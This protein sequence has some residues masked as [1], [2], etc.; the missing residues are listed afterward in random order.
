MTQLMFP[1][2]IAEHHAN[3]S[4]APSSAFGRE[5]LTMRYSIVR[6]SLRFFST[7]VAF[8][9]RELLVG[10]GS[11]LFAILSLWGAIVCGI[12][13][14]VFSL[15]ASG[16]NVALTRILAQ[17]AGFF[18]LF[19]ALGSFFAVRSWQKIQRV[20]TREKTAGVT[21]G[22]IEGKAAAMGE[23]LTGRSRE[24]AA[25]SGAISSDPLVGELHHRISSATESF[26]S[27]VQP[28]YDAWHKISEIRNNFRNEVKTNPLQSVATV[29]VCGAVAGRLLAQRSASSV[30]TAGANASG[31]GNISRLR[32]L[33]TDFAVVLGTKLVHQAIESYTSP[34]QRDA[35]ERTA[36]GGSPSSAQGTRETTG[37][38]RTT[39]RAD[40]RQGSVKSDVMRIL[41]LF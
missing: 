29:A 20:V 21:P 26:Q 9:A 13:A 15:Q 10:I 41:H 35:G 39:V 27:V 25:T 2:Q 24:P 30:Q 34:S 14:I 40:G 38:G 18:I 16:E 12:L 3:L 6:S 8:S 32:G 11:A 5:I 22:V 33:V 37:A 1:V 23:T 19:S 17:A 4:Q 28:A 31:N 7:L 36:A